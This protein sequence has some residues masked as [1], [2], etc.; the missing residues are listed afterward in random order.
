MPLRHQ[1]IRP[2]R[3]GVLNYL[4]GEDKSSEWKVGF[5]ASWH[6]NWINRTSCWSAARCRKIC[7]RSQTHFRIFVSFGEPL[8]SPSLINV[9]NWLINITLRLRPCRRPLLSIVGFLVAGLVAWQYSDRLGFLLACWVFA[10]W[11]LLC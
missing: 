9:R 3:F 4:G 6:P 10:V 2:W 8:A 7:R 1:E 11:C 5:A